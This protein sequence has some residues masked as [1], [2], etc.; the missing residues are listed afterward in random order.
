MLRI[1]DWLC[2]MNISV[3]LCYVC[4][5]ENLCVL[6]DNNNK[7]MC[8]YEFV[9]SNCLFLLTNKEV[10]R[11]ISYCLNV[12]PFFGVFVCNT[13]AFFPSFVLI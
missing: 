6:K 12:Y 1:D 2:L 9:I 10:I 3:C 11:P 7:L 4:V 8:V 13:V 5:Y